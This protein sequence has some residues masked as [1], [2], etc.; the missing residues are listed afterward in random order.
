MKN[1]NKA[2]IDTYE[3]MYDIDIV[4]A[5]RGVTL[6]KLQKLF[7]YSLYVASSSIHSAG[8]YKR[9]HFIAK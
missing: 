9:P 6:E 3:T 1:K 5:N 8:L 7:V 2:I 4:V